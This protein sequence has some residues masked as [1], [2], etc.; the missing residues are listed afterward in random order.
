VTTSLS[1]YGLL[2]LA[3]ELEQAA[4]RVR[5]IR[6]GPRTLD[7]DVIT[8]DDVSSEHPVLTLPHPRAHQRAFVLTPW[9]W[10][11]PDAMLDGV[12]VAELAAQAEDAAAAEHR[13]AEQ[14]DASRRR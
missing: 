3:Q 10:A 14:E 8:Y 4:A 11:D 9:S 13:E 12:A 2:Q 5:D 1:P 7:V 6:W